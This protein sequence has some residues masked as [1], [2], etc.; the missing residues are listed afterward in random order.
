MG[1]VFLGFVVFVPIMEGRI[2]MGQV[3]VWLILLD[4]DHV[5]GLRLILEL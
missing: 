5:E 3:G 4:L 1:N 2:A